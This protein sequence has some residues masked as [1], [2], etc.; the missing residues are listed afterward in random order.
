MKPKKA[1][2]I[3][4]GVG[5]WVAVAAAQSAP[6]SAPAA[7]EHYFFYHLVFLCRPANAPPLDPDVRQKLQEA[8]LANIRRLAKEGKLVLA[9]PFLDDTP[10]RGIF[11]FK[12]ESLEEAKQWTLT[13]PA[14]AADRFV[15][16][17]HTWAQPAST[18]STLPESNPMEN[19]ALV[20]YNKGDKFQPVNAPGMQPVIPRHLAFLK[21]QREA[22]KL[23]AGDSVGMLIFATTPEEASQIVAQDPFVLAGEVKPEVHPRTTQKGVLPK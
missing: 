23:V 14:V 13:D 19:Y 5:A 17:F 8:Q 16:E 6:A 2:A 21:S 4:M 18:F 9:G 15:P 20:L 1:F 10:L 7:P 11:I 3:L 22:G 12:T